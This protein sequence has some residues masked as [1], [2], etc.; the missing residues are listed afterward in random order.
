MITRIFIALILAASMCRADLHS[1]TAAKQAAR[2]GVIRFTYDAVVSIDPVITSTLGDSE[3][4]WTKPN[5]DTFSG[6]APSGTNWTETGTYVL[7]CSDWSKLMQLN[8]NNDAGLITFDIGYRQ[9]RPLISLRRLYLHSTSVYGNISGWI[10]P[11]SLDFLYLYNTSVYGNISGWILPASLDY[12]YMSNTSVSGDISGWILPASLDYLDLFNTSVSGD[13][14]VWTLPA[15]LGYLSMYNTS[16][17]GD[18]SGWTLP[19]SLEYLRLSDTSVSGDISGWTL[20]AAMN[21]LQLYNTSCDY[22]SSSGCFTNTPSSIRKIRMDNCTLTSN[23]VDNVLVDCDTSGIAT[24]GTDSITLNLAGDDEAPSSTGL[25]AYTNLVA[26]G[27]T[28]TIN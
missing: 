28:V 26:N 16:V 6:K 3:F 10:L 19:A 9:L 1:F 2:D 18:I 20:P 7:W 8:H 27:L 15:S 22:D 25:T 14:S 11:A 24:N 12:L 4:R 13:I 5:G 23:Q 21:S 17:S